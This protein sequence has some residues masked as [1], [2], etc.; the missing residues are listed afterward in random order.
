MNN[1]LNIR[2][3][4][5]FYRYLDG[6]EEP[7]VVRI[8]SLPSKKSKSDS[9][10]YFDKDGS[11]KRMSLGYL[12]DNYKM[13]KADGFMIFSIVKVGTGVDVIVALGASDD[14][15]TGPYAICRQSV[16]DHFSN[17]SN[18]NED[19]CYVG[20]SISRDTCPANVKFDECMMCSDL[21]F[22]KPIRVYL[23]DTLEDILK[24]FSNSRFDK[25]LVECEKHVLA[26][27]QKVFLGLNKT[28]KDLLESNQFMTDF[29]RC[30]K[31]TEVPFHID[32]DSETLSTENILFLENELKVN[33]METYV[34]R[35]T[36]EIN[37]RAIKR[38]YLLVSS[39]QDKF[40]SVYLVGYDTSDGKYLPRMAI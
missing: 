6:V 2:S 26:S 33:I 36:K 9:V 21:E 34:V 35:Y 23:D 15:S 31:I 8:Y 3:G 11:K 19:I 17:I 29:R 12:L 14:A 28:L 30:F 4:D 24:L 22:S 32:E 5:K 18:T 25:A 37:L 27:S 16:Y 1:E 39:A 40:N 13:L 10:T 7:E 20:M 38:D